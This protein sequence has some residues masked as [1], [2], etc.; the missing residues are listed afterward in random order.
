MDISLRSW[1]EILKWMADFGRIAI[2]GAF[3]GRALNFVEGVFNFIRIVFNSM[4]FV[5]NFN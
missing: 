2:N 3:V 4:K 5:F 1:N